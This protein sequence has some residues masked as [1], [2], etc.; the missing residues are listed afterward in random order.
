MKKEEDVKKEEKQKISEKEENQKNDLKTTVELESKE[1]TM[2]EQKN[3]L[4][5]IKN[6]SSSSKD[7]KRKKKGESFHTTEVVILIVLTCIISLAMGTMLAY[8]MF[9][10]YQDSSDI[11]VADKEIQTFI[12][13]YNY[14]LENYYGDLDKKELINSAI[15]GMLSSVGDPYS[16]FLDKED[17]SNFNIRL[18]GSYEGVG[19]EV[20]N[21]ADESHIVI[22]SII[23]NS[24]AEKAGLKALDVILSINGKDM[25]G[26]TTKELT[27]Y[28][29]SFKEKE[30]E[31]VVQRGKEE[32]T[33][34]VIRERIVLDSV[35]SNVYEQN[36]KKIGYLGITIFANNTYQQVKTALENLEKQKIDSLIIDVRSN[37]GG[38][39][40]AAK[41]ILS[42][43]MDKKHVIYQ[44]Q[45]KEQKE[46]FYST[47]SKNKAYPIVVLAN[48]DSASASEVVLAALMEELD[49]T[50][51]GKKTFG[52]GTVQELRT[53]PGGSKYKFST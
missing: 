37:S 40:L 1:K 49:A 50:F 12:E 26:K 32:L 10:D 27:S 47:G 48:E 30:F 45:D 28:I 18:E 34:K 16:S 6:T 53:L 52:K 41:N 29:S 11:Q 21:T 33:Y 51:I 13:N 39:L 15:E 35:T 24:P 17:S 5:P 22:Y 23:P 20:V 7:K 14:I 19:I 46:K 9:Q 4:K 38:H 42:L 2:T 3:E 43:F 36:G 25:K 44:T 8:K 31:I